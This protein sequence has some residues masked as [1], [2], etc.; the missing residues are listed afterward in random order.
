MKYI[1][2]VAMQAIGPLSLLGA[3]IFISRAWGAAEQ[4]EYA[5]A[6]SLLDV[7]TALGCFGFPQSVVLAVNRRFASRRILIKWSAIYAFLL[8]P[9]IAIVAFLLSEGEVW[10]WGLAATVVGASLLVMI[11]IWRGVVLTVDDGVL[12][13]LFTLIPT[14]SLAVSVIASMFFFNSFGQSM[15][16]VILA[17]GF[18]G[19]I[20]C[21]FLMPRAKILELDGVR[22]SILDLF[23]D[24]GDVFVQSILG[25]TQVFICYAWLKNQVGLDSVGQFSVSLLILNTFGFPLQATTPILFNKWSVGLEKEVLE[26]GK[27]KFRV[28]FFCLTLLS[29]VSGV[30]LPVAVPLIFGDDLVSAGA[31]ASVLFWALPFMF[32]LR[33]SNL[34]LA[35]IGFLR[36][37]SSI[38]V[39]KFLFFIA[40][41]GVLSSG[42]F[43][44]NVV[45]GAAAAWVLA[46]ACAAILIGLKIRK[47][48]F[49]FSF[50]SGIV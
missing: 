46:E 5:S 8:I 23:K 43:V 22:P 16:Y 36:H 20:L 28:A 27:I 26:A 2:A 37:N 15:P 18:C 13:N 42:Y 34:R 47:M 25:M 30:V 12:F 44:T 50:K 10:G 1:L 39:V 33:V 35:S 14:L 38:A 3:S 49:G 11:M 19:A 48:I 45:L 6:K 32:F 29:L 9:G 17:A 31:V 7:L 24:G 40:F 41:L 4:G 21:I